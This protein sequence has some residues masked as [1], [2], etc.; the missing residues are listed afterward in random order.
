MLSRSMGVE[1]TGIR[2]FLIGSL[3]RQIDK[4]LLVWW[5]SLRSGLCERLYS[6]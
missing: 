6:I 4:L 5:L 2:D 1:R 3:D